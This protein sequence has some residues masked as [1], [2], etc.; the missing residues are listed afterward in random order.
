MT[1]AKK[2]EPMDPLPRPATLVAGRGH[3]VYFEV[4]DYG[5]PNTTVW[6]EQRRPYTQRVTVSHRDQINVGEAYYYRRVDG[7]TLRPGDLDTL[8]NCPHCQRRGDV[9]DNRKTVV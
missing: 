5:D 2:G 6:K 4:Y 8:N 7:E 3:D 9:I 1:V